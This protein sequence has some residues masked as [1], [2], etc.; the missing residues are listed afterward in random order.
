MKIP[1]RWVRNSFCAV[2]AGLAVNVAQAEQVA[3]ET[4]GS[5]SVLSVIPQAMASHWAADGVDLQLILNQTLTKSLL[6]LGQ[7]TLDT[8]IVPPLAYNAL[9]NGSG[10]YAGLGDK[11]VTLSKDVRALFA[12]PGSPFHP[13]VWADSGIKT[14]ADA[15]DKRIYIGPP[16]G[17]ANKQ[18]I[19]LTKEGGL[20]EGE[21]EPVKA[22]W[23]AANQGF[24]DGQYDVYIGAFGLGSQVLTEL[25]LSRDVY[26]LTL[27]EDTVPPKGWGLTKVV[28]EPGTYAGQTNE[29][30]VTTWGTLMM[31]AS[32]KDLS[33]DI[34]YQLTKTY[35]ENR[36]AVAETNSLLRLLPKTGPFDGLNAPLHPGA[37]RY[38]KEVGIEIPA[39]LLPPSE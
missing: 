5:A 13:I 28:I 34:A 15:K 24:Q 22:P 7:G 17:A 12:I 21:Y 38:Y 10:P 23:G 20:E 9:S 30:P 26:F 36:A 18:L 37:V 6:K 1:S 16:A 14:W 35:M 19:A 4:T 8:A 31:M 25:S 29:K 39:E 33:D 2:V 27:E 3:M 11:A 32:R